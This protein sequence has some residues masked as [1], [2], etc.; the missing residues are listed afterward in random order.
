MEI[1]TEILRVRFR[2]AI[3]EEVIAN[4]EFNVVEDY[5]LRAM[6]AEIRL[7]M[8]QRK[9]WEERHS[10]YVPY[11]HPRSWWDAFKLRY[12][13]KWLLDYF[14]VR[15]TTIRIQQ[16][17]ITKHY[18]VCPHIKIPDQATHIQWMVNERV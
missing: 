14:P 18:H 7:K 6:I 15:L 2:S 8:L 3:P 11:H 4:A 10:T 12:F 13:P 5:A 9:Q 1:T 17:R 16:N